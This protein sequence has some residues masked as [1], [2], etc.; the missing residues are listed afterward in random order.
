MNTF[1]KPS[2]L[3][4]VAVNPNVYLVDTFGN[5]LEKT[6]EEIWWQFET[7]GPSIYS[8]WFFEVTFVPIIKLWLSSTSISYT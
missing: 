4:G 5:A 3:L 2:L 7:I 6:S 8:F 1:V